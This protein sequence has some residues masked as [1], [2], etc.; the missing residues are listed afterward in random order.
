[1]FICQICNLFGGSTFSAVLRHMGEIHRYDLGLII[2]CGIYQCPQTYSNYES[3]RSHVYRKHRKYF[4]VNLLAK[5]H[6]SFV[7]IQMMKLLKMI[8]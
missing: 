8:R 5:T 4:I 3:F 6:L 2:R 7:E 1:M